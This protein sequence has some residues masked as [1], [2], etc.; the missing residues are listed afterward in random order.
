LAAALLDA[1]HAVEVVTTADAPPEARPYPVRWISRARPAPLRHLAV[2]REIAR[3]ARRSDRVYATSMVRRS[4]LGAVLAHRPLVAK[5]VSDEAFERAARSGRFGGQLEEFTTHE[6]GACA[7][8]LR[9]T[10]TA[11][12]RRATRVIVPS[13]YLRDL[14]VGWGLPFERVAV[15]PDHAAHPPTLPRP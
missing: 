5:L 14:A 12:L 9:M 7:S 15:A 11:A 8:F 10:R 13:A 3:A 1:G 4:A 2:T 6:G